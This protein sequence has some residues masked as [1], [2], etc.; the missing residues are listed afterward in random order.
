MHYLNSYNKDLSGRCDVANMI[1]LLEEEH[2]AFH[3]KYSYGNNSVEQFEE[4][5]YDYI[6][7]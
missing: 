7:A 4:F 1:V 5:M 6:H 3:K 2:K